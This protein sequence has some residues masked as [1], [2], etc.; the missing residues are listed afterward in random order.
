MKEVQVYSPATIANLCCGFDVLGMALNEPADE[1]IFRKSPSPGVHITKILGAQLSKQPDKNVVGVVLEKILHHLSNKKLGIEVEIYKNIKPGSGIGSSAASA[2]GA[3]VGANILLGTNLKPIDLI[4]FAL[5]G[6]RLASGTGHADNVAPAILGGISLV[7]SY[8][9]LEIISLPSPKK[10]WATIIH[11]DIEIKTLDARQI[12][13]KKV[14]M[15]DAVKQWGNVGALVSALYRDDV[16]LL[17]RSLEDFI[18]EPLRSIF[19]PAFYALKIECK[20][21]GAIGGGI[22]GSGPS[23]FMLSKNKDIA[24]KIAKRMT[25][26]YTFLPIKYRIYI[27]TINNTGVKYN[28]K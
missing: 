5:E 22:S 10:L 7:K 3:A 26:I 18:A 24:E 14:S 12:L 9:P 2:A 1:M 21:V 8:C 16:Y 4:K 28:F 23:V 17:N 27:S 15:K 25:E 19:I 13:N 6:E 20:K 11:P